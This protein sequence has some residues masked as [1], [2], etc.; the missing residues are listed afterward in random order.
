MTGCLKKL[1]RG[2][3]NRWESGKGDGDALKGDGEALDAD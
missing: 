3:K 1:Q 2:I